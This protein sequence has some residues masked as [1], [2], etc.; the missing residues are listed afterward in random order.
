MVRDP[1][2]L[3]LAYHLSFKPRGNRKPVP[4]SLDCEDEWA[5]LIKHVKLHVT[6]E[7]SKDHRRSVPEKPWSVELVDLQPLVDG[8][9]KVRRLLFIVLV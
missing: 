3:K 7:R 5:Q 6:A 9:K 2:T 8:V 1:A 4:T